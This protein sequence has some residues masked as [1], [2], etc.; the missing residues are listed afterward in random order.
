MVGGD[1]G[2]A[3]GTGISQ[4]QFANMNMTRNIF[5]VGFALFMGLS[6]PQYFREFELRAGHG[7]VHTNARW[8]S[9][10]FCVDG[11]ACDRSWMRLR[12]FVGGLTCKTGLF[13]AVQR[14]P[15][16][17]LRCARDS[18]VRC[19]DSAGHHSDPARIE[20]GPGYA[21]DSQVPALRA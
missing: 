20:E 21:V 13:F 18:G 12:R 19:G 8:V 15:E 14:H 10:W 5:V 11:W 1:V 7:P 2:C 16:Y 17:I 6:V 9:R 3:V 4:L